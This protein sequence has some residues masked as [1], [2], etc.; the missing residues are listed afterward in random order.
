MLRTCT[1]RC[2]RISSR[3]EGTE[4]ESR[5]LWSNIRTSGMAL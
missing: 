4:A 3:R 2:H 5:N 1:I